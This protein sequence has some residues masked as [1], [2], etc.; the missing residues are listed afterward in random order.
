MTGT[1]YIAGSGRVD[2]RYPAFLIFLSQILRDRMGVPTLVWRRISFEFETGWML[3]TERMTGFGGSGVS[4]ES[5]RRGIFLNSC[6]SA[7]R[8]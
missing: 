4:S 1:G 5:S 8:L 2:A 6:T 7:R 3:L